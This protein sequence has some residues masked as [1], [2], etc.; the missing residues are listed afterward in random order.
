MA[1]GSGEVIVPEDGSFSAPLYLRVLGGALFLPGPSGREV[2]KFDFAP[3][4]VGTT[5]TVSQALL[6]HDVQINAVGVRQGRL[7]AATENRTVVTQALA[8]DVCQTEDPC[9]A[10]EVGNFCTPGDTD[11]G[12]HACICNHPSYRHAYARGFSP[13]EAWAV[14]SRTQTFEVCLRRNADCGDFTWWSH[15]FRPA[16]SSQIGSP[17]SSPTRSDPRLTVAPRTKNPFLGEVVASLRHAGAGENAFRARKHDEDGNSNSVEA[18]LLHHPEHADVEI[19]ARKSGRWDAGIWSAEELERLHDP[20]A[21]DRWNVL[22][23]KTSF[24]LGPDAQCSSRDGKCRFV[25]VASGSAKIA[26][27]LLDNRRIILR[28]NGGDGD[29]SGNTDAEGQIRLPGGASLAEVSEDRIVHLDVVIRPALSDGHGP[30]WARVFTDGQQI[31]E[32]PFDGYGSSEAERRPFT[33]AAPDEV[34]LW[35]VKD[36]PAPGEEHYH[37]QWWLDNHKTLLPSG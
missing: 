25:K 31:L 30:G 24:R 35:D 19:L 27:F 4:T 1:T 18:T 14:S 15:T 16:G 7:Y 33:N 13:A 11:G 32:I 26:V 21:G 5:G 20:L 2:V 36:G 23:L 29:A 17:G 12:A 6:A 22:T 3:E 37:S 34:R 8:T 10:G 28:Y 9:R